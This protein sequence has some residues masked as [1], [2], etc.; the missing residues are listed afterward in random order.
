MFQG[1]FTSIT[2]VL[3]VTTLACYTYNRIL[4]LHMAI[5]GTDHPKIKWS[6]RVTCTKY[7][8]TNTHMYFAHVC[9]PV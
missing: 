7:V 5:Y 1:H 8:D 3:K 4:C 2:V 9:T 6:T